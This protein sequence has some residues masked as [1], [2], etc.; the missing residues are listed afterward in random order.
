MIL[1]KRNSLNIESKLFQYH[2]LKQIDTFVQ[3]FN[4]DKSII[5][6]FKMQQTEQKFTQL[7]EK[8]QLKN[9]DFY[10][11]DGNYLSFDEKNEWIFRGGI[12]FIFESYTISIGWNNEMHL[13]EMVE[14]ELDDLIGEL[15]VYD[16]ELGELATIEK[17]KGQKVKNIDFKWTFYQE[18]D[19]EMELTDEKTYIPQELKLEFEDGTKMQVAGIVFQLKD[20]QIHNPVYD[21]QSMLMITVD[22][23]V[24][25]AEMEE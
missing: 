10:S 5:S 4:I 15:D 24:E 12:E 11:I 3:F 13:N 18:M 14:G 17:L 21:P 16:L 9:I 19:E 7:F 20:N 8:E 1:K 23:E 25:I 6:G 2:F 22:K